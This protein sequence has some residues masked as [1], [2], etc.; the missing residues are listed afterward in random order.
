MSLVTRETPPEKP[1]LV[2][3]TLLP[4][5]KEDYDLSVDRISDGVISNAT[6]GMEPE[7]LVTKETETV[8][9]ELVT[10][11][12]ETE[13]LSSPQHQEPLDLTVN[14]PKQPRSTKL[15]PTDRYQRSARL[16]L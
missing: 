9:P 2:A 14:Q 7:S 11:V 13:E 5:T 16:R 12:S 8:E 1:E 6:M 15:I 4:P 10:P 3:D